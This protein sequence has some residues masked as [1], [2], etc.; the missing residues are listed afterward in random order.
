MQMHSSGASVRDIRAANEPWKFQTKQCAVRLAGIALSRSRE[1]RNEAGWRFG[2][3][4][5]VFARFQTE[6]VW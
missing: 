6:V 2:V 4:P 5:L 3:E 1:R